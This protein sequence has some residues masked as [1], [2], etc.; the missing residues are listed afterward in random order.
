[1]Y[2]QKLW[3]WNV[4]DLDMNGN[5]NSVLALCKG[6]YT[7]ASR[8]VLSCS[9][10]FFT[11]NQPRT[12]NH[13]LSTANGGR[14]LGILLGLQIRPWRFLGNDDQHTNTSHCGLR[15]PLCVRPKAEKDWIQAN[16]SFGAII[17]VPACE[18][19]ALEQFVNCSARK[20]IHA[21][22]CEL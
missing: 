14:A 6:V 7:L 17:L 1:M 22:T 3:G 5:Y 2:Q 19:A 20:C 4:Q 13:H 12:I 8:T 9:L 10:K 18:P 16:L 21:F 11:T 15:A